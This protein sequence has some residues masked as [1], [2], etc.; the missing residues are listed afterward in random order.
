MA[1]GIRLLVCQQVGV[2]Q[3]AKSIGWGIANCKSH[4]LPTATCNRR[5]KMS[6]DARFVNQKGSEKLV[7]QAIV[8]IPK[9]NFNMLNYS[10]H[11]DRSSNAQP[12]LPD[13]ADKE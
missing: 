10:T 2:L 13:R 11:G 3:T 12:D 5:V 4:P 7:Q 1:Y 8:F 6:I 9:G